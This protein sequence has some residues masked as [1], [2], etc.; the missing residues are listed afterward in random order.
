M[1]TAQCPAMGPSWL[2]SL[3]V[4]GLLLRWGFLRRQRPPKQS[5][6]NGSFGRKFC[7]KFCCNGCLTLEVYAA[8]FS[9]HDGSSM[10][11]AGGGRGANEAKVFDRHEENWTSFGAVVRLVPLANPPGCARHPR[12]PGPL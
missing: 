12:F 6:N 10:I 8:Q 3:R 4:L 9:K 1:A 7:K 5:K 11:A 2:V